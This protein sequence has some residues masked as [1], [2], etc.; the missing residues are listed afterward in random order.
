MLLSQHKKTFFEWRVS[1]F[2]GYGFTEGVGQAPFLI[3]YSRLFLL[4]CPPAETLLFC[5][6]GEQV[7]RIIAK[8]GGV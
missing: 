7:L 8:V 4:S 1:S 6:C 3:V 2:F 5:A